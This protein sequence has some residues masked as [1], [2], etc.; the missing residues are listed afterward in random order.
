M[1]SVGDVTDVVCIRTVTPAAVCMAASLPTPTGGRERG[2]VPLDSG[3]SS[4]S[5]AS[6]GSK[7][8]VAGRDQGLR[9]VDRST[10]VHFNSQEDPLTLGPVDLANLRKTVTVH[11]WNKVAQFRQY[12]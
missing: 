7:R 6:I 12:H 3:D 2:S 10:V 1:T 9:S 8:A 4:L 5:S 11:L